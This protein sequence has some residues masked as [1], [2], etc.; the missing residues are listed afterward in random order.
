MGILGRGEAF[1]GGGKTTSGA[2]GQRRRLG[3][4]RLRGA[5]RQQP[6]PPARRVRRWRPTTTRGDCARAASGVPARRCPP[7]PSRVAASIRPPRQGSPEPRQRRCS[8]CRVPP[9]ARPPPPTATPARCACGRQRGSWPAARPQGRQA[10]CA[11]PRWRRVPR[12]RGRRSRPAG[13]R[14]LPVP[15]PARWRRPSARRSGCWRRSPAGAGRT[16]GRPSP[17]RCR[18][19]PRA[20]RSA[21]PVRCA[22]TRRRPP[23]PSRRPRRRRQCQAP[24]AARS[25]RRGTPIPPTLSRSCLPPRPTEML[26]NPASGAKSISRSRS[27]GERIS[28]AADALACCVGGLALCPPAAPVLGIETPQNS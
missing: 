5:W 20:P 28:Q 9:C 11:R 10:P 4:P 27:L 24:P 8:A 3:Q 7:S 26:E 15:R 16:V 21:P 14:P 22:P 12:S 25:C 23:S 6:S 1:L 2:G 19:R 18:H 17:A 13:S